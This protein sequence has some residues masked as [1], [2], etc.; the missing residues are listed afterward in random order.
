MG[1]IDYGIALTAKAGAL[2]QTPNHPNVKVIYR[3]GVHTARGRG[4]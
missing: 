1:Y 3:K 4:I 2:I